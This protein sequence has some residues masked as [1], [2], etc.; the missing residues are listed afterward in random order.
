M[1]VIHSLYADGRLFLGRLLNW[2]IEYR[3]GLCLS[4][5][6]LT[7]LFGAAVPLLKV[8]NQLEALLD[9]EST[10]YQQYETFRLRFGTDHVVIAGVAVPKGADS[11]R[12]LDAL[13]H[14]TDRLAHIPQVARITSIL[15][16]AT[17]RNSPQGIVQWP[18]VSLTG[19]NQTLSLDQR[20]LTLLRQTWPTINRL[21]SRDRKTLGI[22]VHLKPSETLQEDLKDL[23]PQ[24]SAAIREGFH[25]ISIDIHTSGIP[26]FMEAMRRYNMENALVFLICA[27]VAGILIELYIF[28]SSIVSVI[29]IA[30][31]TLAIIWGVGFMA[32]TGVALNPISGM[33]YGIILILTTMTVIHITTHYY[34]QFIVLRDRRQALRK[35]LSVV[36]QPSLMCTVT[37]AIG[38]SSIVISPVP[39]VK[40][41]GYIMASGALVSFFLV[42]CI[43][44]FLLLNIKH[45]T[46][47]R[48]TARSG[49]LLERAYKKL[50]RWITD[51]PTRFLLVGLL[52]LVIFA[53]GIP[54]IK[55]NTQIL[56]LFQRTSP[57][58]LD[59]QFIQ[60]ELAAAN[61][62]NVLIEATPDKPL[63]AK[64]L[65]A[66]QR[67]ESRLLGLEEIQE[68]ESFFRIL[69]MIYA[70]LFDK[71][72]HPKG[73]YDSNYLFQD[74]YRRVLSQPTIRPLL[75]GVLDFESRSFCMALRVSEPFDQQFER[76]ILR[77]RKIA[78]E[79]ISGV[80]RCWVTGTHVVAA[81][82]STRL[83]KAQVFSLSLALLSISALLMIQFR[84]WLL[85]ALSLI[86]NLFPLAALFGI[87]G[88]CGIP[89]DN[90]TILVAV[91]SFGLSVD[92]TIHYL[93]HLRHALVDQPA[94]RAVIKAV[95]KAYRT[96]AKALIS[97]SAVLMFSFI[98]LVMSPFKPTAD[99]GLLSSVAA[100]TALAADLILM[101]AIMLRSK[102][103]QRALAFAFYRKARVSGHLSIIA[104]PVE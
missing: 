10:A 78:A 22:L 89:L 29:I 88:W 12:A 26:V 31:S 98:T 49:D 14:A 75:R 11:A 35:A 55:V 100:L 42:Y 32:L 69:E 21:I 70:G 99:F 61:T 7:F 54:R 36:G 60:R 47:D 66:I 40:Q 74:V 103:L 52:L 57:E 37:T 76:L 73:L 46:P 71:G 86:P 97:T 62:V 72:D 59:F 83:I 53:M 24:L 16:V 41:F 3:K 63:N 17:I 13:T 93:T 64:S 2:I 19:P 91:I 45:A 50:G 90:I 92:D 43:L 20:L 44:P 80:G 30:I 82:Q 27:A 95:Q 48:I 94:E 1:S 96:S 77:I 104:N 84:S 101:P 18:L 25:P 102:V 8:D 28:K 79:E 68:S 56:N 34:D 39:T 51:Y 4:A 38:F 67:F 81:I 33:A 5:L 23:L 65:R 58:M 15:D 6:V 85:G 87:M 9:R